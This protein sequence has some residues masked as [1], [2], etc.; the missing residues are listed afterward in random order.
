M[1]IDN[2]S[3]R[4]S[5]PVGFG[6]LE[7][8]DE[9]PDLQ[10]AACEFCDDD[11]YPHAFDFVDGGYCC[12]DCVD[13]PS[14]ADEVAEARRAVLQAREAASSQ[15]RPEPPQPT[16]RR[17]ARVC[18]VPETLYNLERSGPG[19]PSWSSYD[20]G[21]LDSRHGRVRD[22]TYP[23][24]QAAR[25]RLRADFEEAKLENSDLAGRLD[26]VYSRLR[27]LVQPCGKELELADCERAA[28]IILR[29]TIGELTDEWERHGVRASTEDTAASTE[30]TAASADDT[31]YPAEASAA[32]SA[33]LFERWSVEG[34]VRMGGV[35][36]TEGH[37][38]IDEAY[39]FNGFHHRASR[40]SQ[41][42]TR[43][44]SPAAREAMLSRRAEAQSDLV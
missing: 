34:S 11:Q 31:S 7:T 33:I 18:K 10:P 25:D 3:N 30:D 2:D 13:V 27:E 32:A 17:S 12:E 22:E 14:H 42:S 16:V 5:S 8:D 20:L 19:Q 24:L 39:A 21:R 26:R 41:H 1:D 9:A 36:G 43:T 4:P 38:A 15:P 44:P 37:L 6:D 35:N 28:A 29:E 40:T 23:E